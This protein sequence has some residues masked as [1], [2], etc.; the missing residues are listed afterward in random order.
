MPYVMRKIKNENLYTV[1]NKETR[2]VH[3]KGT[4]KDKAK[5]MI[6]ILD[7]GAQAELL[8]GTPRQ[9]RPQAELLEGNGLKVYPLGTHD[10][11]AEKAYELIWKKI[12]RN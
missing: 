7:A 2:K 10:K 5:A 11:D 6:R 4:T 8:A 1:K 3:A 12:C 9:P